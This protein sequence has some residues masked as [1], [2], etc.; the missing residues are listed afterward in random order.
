MTSDLPDGDAEPGGV[1]VIGQWLEALYGDEPGRSLWTTLDDRLRLAFAQGWVF[2]RLNESDDDLAEDLAADDSDNL[3]F[4][5]MLAGFIT[6]LEADTWLIAALA[7]RLPVPGWP[8][9]EMT[10][11]GLHIDSP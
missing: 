2:G 7:R 9:A 6:R 1:E 4:E 11:P 5:E 8:P 10:V 3:L